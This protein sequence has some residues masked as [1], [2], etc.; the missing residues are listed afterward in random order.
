[1]EVDINL[2]N[3][4]FRIGTVPIE[5]ATGPHYV[6]YENREVGH[7]FWRTARVAIHAPGQAVPMRMW[8]LVPCNEY[9]GLH[10]MQAEMKMLPY[11][12]LRTQAEVDQAI[13]MRGLSQTFRV[14]KVQPL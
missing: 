6:I 11:Q 10:Y 1:M 14:F 12:A 2:P 5:P 8:A 7:R 3:P 13:R 4:A 9:G